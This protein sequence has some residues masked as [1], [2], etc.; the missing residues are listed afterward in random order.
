MLAAVAD[1]DPLAARAD[2]VFQRGV[3]VERVAHLVEIRHRNIR[4]LAH[5]A[6]RAVAGFGRGGVG[7]CRVGFELAQ[8]QLEQRGFAC[9]VGSEQADFVPAQNRCRE[10]VH[11]FP[12][13]KTLGH[14]RQLGDQF[15]ADCAAVHIHIHAANHFA[16]CL[17]GGA[18]IVQPHDAR[19]RP[20]AAG[21]HAFADPDL[22]LRQQLVRAC[23]DHRLLR[24]L[25]F[26]LQ[27]VGREVARVG[28]Q[29]AAIQLDDAGGHVVQKRAIVGD[30]DDAALE[31]DQQAL[32][33]FNRIEV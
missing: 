19:S 2:E 1:F 17:T 26:F 28:Q 32:Q 27:Q 5:R 15:A 8:N 11:D 4:A 6:P 31:V 30:G 10:V 23:I 29:L 20:G 21:L 13:A 16:A 25:L 9:A 7:R 12:V 18:Q 14:M 33:P 22:F 3:H 24:Q